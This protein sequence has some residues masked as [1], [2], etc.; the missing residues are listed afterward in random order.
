[1]EITTNES[2][3]LFS[4]GLVV[5]ASFAFLTP[6]NVLRNLTRSVTRV[7][8]SSTKTTS[9]IAPAGT[10]NVRYFSGFSRHTVECVDQLWNVGSFP[11]LAHEKRPMMYNA[12][13]ML[14]SVVN[15]T[16]EFF[17]PAPSDL[18]MDMGD[19][20][21]YHA[22]SVLRKRRKKMNKHKHEKRMKAL[23]NRTKKN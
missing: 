15:P 3:E 17:Y 20:V 7:C 1:M 2:S 21:E 8:H 14:M 5:S 9:V 6:M 13:E 16:V 12:N 18:I 23:R 22:D 19:Q 4:C 11:I 10:T